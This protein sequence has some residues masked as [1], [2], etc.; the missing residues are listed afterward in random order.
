MFSSLMSDSSILEIF[1]I[2]LFT[3]L[4]WPLFANEKTLFHKIGSTIHYVII[5]IVTFLIFKI[6][7]ISKVANGLNISVVNGFDIAFKTNHFGIIFASIIALL[8]PAAY[9]Y[10]IGYLRSSGEVDHP[11]YL[12][13][14]N[15]SFCFTFALCFAANLLTLFICYELVSLSTIPLIAHTTS[16]HVTKSVK[17]YIIYLFGGS[18]ALWLPALLYI[19]FHTSNH[20]FVIGGIEAIS[21][22]SPELKLILFLMTLF[23]ILKT[24]I[25]PF[26]SWL[27]AAMAANYPTSSILHGVLVVNSGLYCLFKFIYEVFGINIVMN[28]IFENRFI[29][30]L[31]II[32]I[33]Y[34]GFLA[35]I[36]KTVK[37]ILAWSTVSQLNLIILL[38]ISGVNFSAPLML[39][40]M[41]LHSFTKITLFF[42][43]GTVYI[44]SRATNIFEFREV[45]EKFKSV[46]ICFVVASI[47]LAGL[48]IFKNGYLKNII[49]HFS[50]ADSMNEVT[51][52]IISSSILSVIYLGRV[53]IEMTANYH[54]DHRVEIFG[55]PSKLIMISYFY[56]CFLCV[57]VSFYSKNI[58]VFLKGFLADY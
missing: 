53:G 4:L 14:L 45:I 12:F 20:Y 52:G 36:Q 11:R 55:I 57:L 41:I 33:I 15:L 49:L 47:C 44:R 28:I 46:F 16:D 35:V 10:S 29:L 1:F 26:H 30:L 13:F 27:P 42:T 5:I 25:F 37:K 39:H 31:P 56:T 34:S 38:A 6:F 8:W 18:I 3:T 23:G 21:S 24:A 32:G 19:K 2:S 58:H 17:K 7:A 51:F 9:L 48:P 40:Y 22:F 54:P 50:N 43:M